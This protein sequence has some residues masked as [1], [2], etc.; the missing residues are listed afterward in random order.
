MLPEIVKIRP[1]DVYTPQRWQTFLLRNWGMV[2]AKKLADVLRVREDTVIREANRLGLVSEYNPEWKSRGYITLIKNN[3]HLLPYSQLVELLDTD[4]DALDFTLREDDFL[5]IKLGNIKPDCEEMV[6]KPLTAEEIEETKVVASIIK[7]NYNPNYERPFNFYFTDTIVSNTKNNANFDKIVYSYSTLYG[8]ALY[9]GTEIIP[10]ILLE[11]L[12]SVGVNGIWMQGLLSK[13]SYY[14]YVKGES[15]GYEIRRKNLNKLIKKCANYGI[16][17]YL[18]MNEP[19]GLTEDRFNEETEKLKGREFDG[20]WSLCTERKEVKEYL[21]EAVKD[22]VKAVPELGGIITIT[23]SENLTNCY[24]RPGNDCPICSKL[25]KSYVVPEVNNVIQRAITDAGVGVRLIANLW[26]WSS[27]FGWTEEEVLEGISNLDP[28]INV[29]CVSEVGSILQ[30][31][32]IDNITEYT[33]SRIGPSEETKKY[34]SHARKLSHKVMT[35]VQ[36]NNTWEFPIVPYI[37]VFDSVIKHAENLKALGIEGMMASWTLGGYPTVSLDLINAVFSDN[38]D[39]DAW[40]KKH[41]QENSEVVKKCSS[42]L[43]KGFGFF[44]F[45]IDTLY[46]ACQAQ[47]PSNLWYTR[48]TGLKAGMVT[49]PYDDV[50]SWIGDKSVEEFLS[51]LD[52]MLSYFKKGIESLEGISG[53]QTFDEYKRFA[54]VFYVNMSSLA[55]QVRFNT[56]KESADAKTLLRYVEEEKVLV[57]KLFD[58]AGQDCRIGYEAS[59]HYYFTQNTFLEKMLNIDYLEKYYR[60]KIA[61]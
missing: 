40:L 61:D 15:E 42:Y 10:E 49:M 44:P 3:W 48:K 28:K 38:F 8:D 23:M 11:K 19:R 58:L 45:H 21:Y 1:L 60:A 52:E 37:P 39:Y 16:K 17:I 57:R 54:N 59:Q 27:L 2:S 35:K 53:N 26:S 14:P 13:L 6:Y 41:F 4:K 50:E 56:Q 24:A 31:G 36:I 25:K 29:L 18:Y 30:N 20:V 47:G 51:L 7:N 22:F 34:L 12:Q 33:M 5:N 32:K 46:F 55:L 9:D 43:S